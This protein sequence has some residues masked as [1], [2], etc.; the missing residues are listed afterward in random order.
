ML[1]KIEELVERSYPIEVKYTGNLKK[2][3]IVAGASLSPNRIMISGGGS[4][5]DQI[6]QIAAD[7]FNLP[8]SRVQ[9]FETSTLGA[10]IAGFIASGVY[11][12]GLHAVENMVRITRTF[13]PNSSNREIY[14]FMY[15]KGYKK[16][17]PSL[18][19]IYKDIKN[20]ENRKSAF[21]RIKAA[22]KKNK[23]I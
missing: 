19:K 20:F 16:M 8:V 5:S 9:T 7:I 21:E 1:L 14:D 17:Y 15:K 22:L 12:N 10:A 3:Y 6:C 18:R 11:K 13:I 2:G 23:N 4:Q